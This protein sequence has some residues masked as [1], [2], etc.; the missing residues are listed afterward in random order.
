MPTWVTNILYANCSEEEWDA[1]KEAVST[2]EQAISFNKL[3]PLPDE[4]RNTPATSDGTNGMKYYRK[5]LATTT[6]E[7]A[8]AIKEKCAADP[9]ADFALG[10]QY[11]ANLLK[12]GATCWLDWS[13]AHWGTKWDTDSTY[14]D[15]EER[16]FVFE[17]ASYAP[18]PILQ[19]LVNMFPDIEFTMEWASEDIGENCGRVVYRSG[20]P[21]YWYP[22]GD[23]AIEFACEILGRDPDEYRARMAEPDDEIEA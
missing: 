12:Y 15:D 22:D 11:H 13:T 5:Y 20:E 14:A 18:H 7:A 17:T 6:P 8:T 9:R 23:Q 2:D 19:T 4:L 16:K 10:E 3:I 1:L 21:E